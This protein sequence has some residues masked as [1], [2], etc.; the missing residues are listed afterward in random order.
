MWIGHENMW[1]QGM[2]ICVDRAWGYVGTGHGDMC[3]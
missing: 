3:G 1:G 2:G